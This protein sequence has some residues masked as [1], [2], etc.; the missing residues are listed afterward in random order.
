MMPSPLWPCPLRP[1]CN[2]LLYFAGAGTR[3]VG[4]PA[5]VDD[6]A[7][8][9]DEVVQGVG[10]GAELVLHVHHLLPV[11]RECAYKLGQHSFPFHLLRIAIST[12][13]DEE[14]LHPP[15]GSLRTKNLIF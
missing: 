9:C 7:A 3:G 10:A 14:H 13:G 1:C 2:T 6:G 4:I 11:A 8:V 15:S 12:L 5:H